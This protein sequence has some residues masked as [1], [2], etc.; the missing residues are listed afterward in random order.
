[1][2]IPELKRLDV[3]RKKADHPTLAKNNPDAI[4]P[5]A[6]NQKNANGL[7][8]CIIDSI[9]LTGGYA[10][11]IN[12]G[13]TFRKGKTI[14]RDC[15]GVVKTR[16]TF[17]FNGTRGVADIDAIHNGMPVKIEVKFGKDKMSD[18]QKKYQE[19]I[20]RSGGIYIVARTLESFWI[21]WEQKVINIKP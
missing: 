6:Y 12:N 2:T 7:T 20:E 4:S 10:V 21:E 9:N 1:M 16:D 5:Y 18:A 14:A 13:G 8:R 11:R 15:G 3:E 17:T 19:N